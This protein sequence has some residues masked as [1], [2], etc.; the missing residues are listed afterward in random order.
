M[1]QSENSDAL[2]Q[3][4]SEETAD[5]ESHDMGTNNEH[6][7]LASVLDIQDADA[8][9][10]ANADA[11]ADSSMMMED[12]DPEPI[13]EAVAIPM[14]CDDASVESVDVVA[15]VIREDHNSNG[16]TIDN[17]A[18][19]DIYIQIQ[20]HLQRLNMHQQTHLKSLQTVR[21]KL[22]FRLQRKRAQGQVS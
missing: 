17:S 11:D 8:N 3:L 13:Q 15:E 22:D 12:A 18:D 9:A 4:H 2:M 5:E 20:L 6:A 10:D 19:I 1:A 7:S 14:D 21:N 16:V